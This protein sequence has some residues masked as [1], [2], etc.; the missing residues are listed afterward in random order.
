MSKN[1]INTLLVRTVSQLTPYMVGSICSG[2]DYCEIVHMKSVLIEILLVL[3][4]ELDGQTW[5]LCKFIPNLMERPPNMNPLIT[6]SQHGPI[7]S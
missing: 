5:N 7:D 4:H 3:N 2:V 1:P 6:L